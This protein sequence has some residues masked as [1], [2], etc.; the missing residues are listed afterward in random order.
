MDV[1]EAIKGRRSIR[2]YKKNEVIDKKILEEIVDAGKYAASAR[3]EYPWKF[4]VIT[5]KDR[6]KQLAE[7]IG[8]NG[9]FI[10]DASAAI[11]VIC[12]D[13]KYYLEDGSA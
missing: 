10:A 5:L 8:S 6:L 2:K 4:V 11:V 1:F 3:A 9:R 12:K 13:T 7:I